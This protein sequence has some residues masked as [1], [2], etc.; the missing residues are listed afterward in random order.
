MWISS[1][2]YWRKATLTSSQHFAQALHATPQ[3]PK[4]CSMPVNRDTVIERKV[5]VSHEVCVSMRNDWVLTIQKLDSLR[6]YAWNS[7][8]FISFRGETSVITW[9]KSKL[10]SC[11]SV[12]HK[13]QILLIAWKFKFQMFTRFYG[14]KS[15]H[16]T[17]TWRSRKDYAEK[18]ILYVCFTQT[19]MN[20]MHTECAPSRWG[21]LLVSLMGLGTMFFF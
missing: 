9:K 3:R 16:A 7:V 14:W 19:C 17:T 13:S 4:Y 12:I 15:V 21:L 5:W 1:P 2:P 20:I 6:V 18:L 10:Y 8:F 11:R